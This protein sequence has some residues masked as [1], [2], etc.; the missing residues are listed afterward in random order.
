MGKIV[1]CH[2]SKGCRLTI[3]VDEWIIFGNVDKKDLSLFSFISK[4][5]ILCESCKIKTCNG[6]TI[7]RL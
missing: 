3:K 5:I 6:V 7:T 2:G 4:K 1:M